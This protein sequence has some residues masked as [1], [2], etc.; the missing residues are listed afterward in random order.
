MLQTQR[1]LLRE[2]T[3]DDAWFVVTM[4]ND[5][6]WIRF[7][8]DRNVH[9]RAEAEQ[10]LLRGPL[11]MYARFGHGLWL[12]QTKSAA[13]PIGICGLIAREGLGDVDLGFA[14]LPRHRRQG[15]AFEA[16]SACLAHAPAE[17]GLRRIVAI[18]TLDN[19]ASARLL[20]RLGLR[21]ERMIQ[22]PGSE[23]ELKLFAGEAPFKVSTAGSSH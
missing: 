18:T 9:T 15:Y 7:I 21:F 2:L 3:L 14:L 23:E 17:L 20:E 4:L 1:L 22:L 8:G 12:V 10:Y 6:D 13:E 19:H 5:P 16:A 11:A